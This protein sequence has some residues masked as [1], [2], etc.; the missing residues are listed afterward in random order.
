MTQAAGSKYSSGHS[1]NKGRWNGPGQGN[2][3]VIMCRLLASSLALCLLLQGKSAL[4][5]EGVDR[6]PAI[7]FAA[8]QPATAYEMVVLLPGFHIQ[9]GDATVRGFSGTVGNVLIDFRY[10][11]LSHFSS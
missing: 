5:Q 2:D 7:F 10:H 1:E 9:L 3:I 8:N 4:A 6:Y 11:V